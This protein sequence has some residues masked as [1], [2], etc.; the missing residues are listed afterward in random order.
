MAWKTCKQNTIEKCN[1]AIN[2]TFIVIESCR[3]EVAFEPDTE[4]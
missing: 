4:G 1:K 2:S 3:E